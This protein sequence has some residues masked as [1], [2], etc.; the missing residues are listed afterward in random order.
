LFDICHLCR[1]AA[2]SLP[3]SVSAQ[4]LIKGLAAY[5]EF[6][7]KG[8]FLFSIGDNWDNDFGDWDNVRTVLSI[9]ALFNS[10]ALS[11]K[12]SLRFIRKEPQVATTQRFS[13]TTSLEATDKDSE[14]IAVIEEAAA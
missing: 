9:V 2:F 12:D 8:G 6:A 10:S 13:M 14:S 11:R 7:G 5:A 3:S 1:S 4:V